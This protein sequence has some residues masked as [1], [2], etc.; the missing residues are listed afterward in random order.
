MREK[1][2]LRKRSA[3]NFYLYISPWLIT[4]ILFTVIPMVF[5]LIMS[6]TSAKI[7]TLTTKPLEFVGIKN[8][9]RMFAEDTRFLRSIGNTMLYSVL[10]V[11]LGTI[12]ALLIAMLLN[13]KIPGRKLFRTM[14][15]LPAII[16]IVGSTILWKLMIFQE[17]NI[18]SYLFT[19][20]GLGNPDFLA[21][22]KALYSV[23]WINIWNGLGPSMLILLAGLQGVPQD[24][25]EASQIDGANAFV[26][27][28]KI[29]LPMI[30]STVFFSMITGFIGALQSYAEVKLL[31]GSMT[32]TMTMAMLVVE[33]AF[34]MDAYSMGYASAQGWF[35][36][37]VTLIFTG[38]FFIA[39]KKAV[40]YAEN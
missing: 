22:D 5:S 37:V 9:V 31:T 27:F 11:V 29:I 25:I 38:I 7:A 30:S 24:L 20:L 18:V 21:P 23:V 36:F 19:S 16:P 13:T 26:K 33:N 34:S 17:G 14:I 15:Y 4:F 40:Y 35:I 3:I 32:E 12:F 39:S 2:N 8:Y 10:R 28:F 6:F 1:L